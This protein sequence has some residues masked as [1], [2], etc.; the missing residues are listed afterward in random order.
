MNDR[1]PYESLIAAKLEQ[2]PPLPAMAD[3]IWSRISDD[4][5]R[6]L[7]NDGGMDGNSGPANGAGSLGNIWWP[8]MGAFV[9]LVAGM[10]YWSNKKTPVNSTLTPAKPDS[11][12]SVVPQPSTSAPPAK[13]ESVTTVPYSAGRSDSAQYESRHEN[14]LPL[15]AAPPSSPDSATIAQPQPQATP[16]M[17]DE[18]KPREEPPKVA[19]TSLPDSATGKKSKG[20]T[21]LSQKDYR[22]V[23]GK[24]DSTKKN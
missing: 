16:L 18:S 14:A 4:L 5:D 3:A 9:L 12:E 19:V 11:A 13:N 17:T 10:F 20:I 23:P 22:I 6:E 8:G 2:L 15:T 7:P 21:G 24:K 1:L